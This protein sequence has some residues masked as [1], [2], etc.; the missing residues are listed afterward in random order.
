MTPDSAMKKLIATAAF[1]FIGAGRLF[2][3]APSIE[4]IRTETL[5]SGEHQGD[6]DTVCLTGQNPFASKY[7]VF[8]GPSLPTS[9]TKI[10]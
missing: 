4:P 3:Q 5:A 2:A 6:A 9:F 10:W 8:A 7:L 1:V